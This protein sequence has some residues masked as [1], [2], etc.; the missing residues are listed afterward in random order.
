[1]E[2]TQQFLTQ[3]DCFSGGRTMLPRGVMIHSTGVAQPSPQAF[4]RQWNKQDVPVCVHAFVCE[5]GVIQTLPWNRRSWHA[6]TGTSGRSA[7]NTHIS[8]EICEPKG[9]TYAGG[10]MLNYDVAKN[11]DYFAK[12]YQNAVDLTAMLCKEYRLN[13]LQDGVVICHSE[14]YRRGVASNH[15]DVEQWFPKHGKSMDIF[16]ADVSKAMKGDDGPQGPRRPLS[17][18]DL[19]GHSPVGTGDREKPP[20]LRR[21]PGRR[22]RQPEY[23]PR[24]APRLGDFEP[25]Q[26]VKKYPTCDNVG[27]FFALILC[28]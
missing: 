16:R 26:I 14:G 23:F 28:F 24:S 18:Q 6:G 10:T 12:V 3:N 7:N 20:S 25:R 1:M 21:P 15:A 17:L 27:Y 8:F 4:I 13:P 19:G 9:H 2:L 5:T 11:A 22:L